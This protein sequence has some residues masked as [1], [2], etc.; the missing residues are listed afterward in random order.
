MNIKSY[1]LECNEYLEKE[2]KA[3]FSLDYFG[4]GQPNNPDFINGLKNDFGNTRKKELVKYAQEMHEKCTDDIIEVYDNEKLDTI[5]IVPRSKRKDSYPGEKLYFSLYI[6]W[7]IEITN[8]DENDKIIDGTD[9]II[10]HTDTKTTHFHKHPEYAGD[11]EYPYPGITKDT[12]DISP[13]VKG[14]RILL[15]DDIYTKSINIDEDCIQALYDNGAEKV[16]LYTVAK[17][18]YRNLFL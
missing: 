4:F 10:R 14:K 12:C 6:R 3:Y 9:Y 11:G 1:F 16:I 2:T 7:I 5:C 17:T 18:V 13:N 8:E 15:I